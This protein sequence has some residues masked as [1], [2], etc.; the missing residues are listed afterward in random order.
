MSFLSGITNAVSS[1][2]RTVSSAAQS[3]GK[4]ATAATS[5]LNEAKG[6][7]ASIKSG[8]EK[9]TQGPG[10]LLGGLGNILGGFPGIGDIAKKLLGGLG[11][12]QGGLGG[13]LGGLGGALGG[14][15]NPGQLMQ[16]VQSMIGQVTSA[17]VPG[18]GAVNVPS[19]LQGRPP[20]PTTS[21]GAATGGGAVSG[22][23]DPFADQIRQ[24]GSAS[25]PSGADLAKKYGM[26][27]S[28]PEVKSKMDMMAVQK[29]EQATQELLSFIST[30]NTNEHENKKNIIQNMRA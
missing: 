18:A 15:L 22:S 3:I 28:D 20:A 13:L 23:S 11:G 21:T 25:T 26:D 30:H 7:F 5:A 8:F 14:I 4:V 27:Y 17:N 16:Q 12:G 10:G 2:V 29:K 9:I 6:L 19:V 1:A 24:M